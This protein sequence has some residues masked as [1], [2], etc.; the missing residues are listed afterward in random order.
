M[1]SVGLTTAFVQQV[2][3]LRRFCL[4]AVSQPASSSYT[5]R[6]LSPTNSVIEGSLRGQGIDRIGPS[7]YQTHTNPTPQ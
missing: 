6:R 3:D 1:D 5:G 2:S 4:L 7:V